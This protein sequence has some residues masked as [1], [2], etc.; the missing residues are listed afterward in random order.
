MAGACLRVLTRC[1]AA[2]DGRSASITWHC[3]TAQPGR[4][5][6]DARLAAHGIRSVLNGS[7]KSFSFDYECDAP[8]DERWF[9]CSVNPL[10]G[11]HPGVVVMHENISAS[12]RDQS[13]LVSLAERLS[14]A[15][16]VARVGVWEWNI[17]SNALTWNSTMFAIYGLPQSTPISYELWAQ[18]VNA[19]DLGRVESTTQSA[20]I[21]QSEEIM[22]FR[23]IAG[24]GNVRYVS[25]GRERP[26][27]DASG[28]VC[29]VIGV[30]LDITERKKAEQ[31]LRSNQALM[32]HLAGHDFL[33]DLPNQR[34]LRDR[35]DQAVKLAFRNQKKFAVLFFD[36][37]GFKHINDSLGHPIG[38]KIL[39]SMAKRLVESGRASDTIGRFG[40]DEFPCTSSGGR[41]SGGNRRSPLYE[42]LKLSPQFT[43]STSLNFKSQHASESAYIRTMVWIP[44]RSSRTPMSRCTTPK[45]E[46]AQ[47]FSS[48]TLT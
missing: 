38:D 4:A 10:S 12:K 21:R 6:Q 2:P 43:P 11:N 18:A 15:T 31:E 25:G 16:E 8:I 33:T 40:G 34:L 7:N 28:Q 46:A 35:I 41:S 32:T 20:I 23:I 39:L 22:E 29:R 47:I 44:R 30:N 37:D 42:C 36:L 9:R 48:S 1:A 14:L 3:A 19:E 5:Q 45:V 27:V 24:D 13:S 26:V 17:A